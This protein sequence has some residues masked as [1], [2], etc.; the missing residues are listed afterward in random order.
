MKKMK[1]MKKTFYFVRHAEATHNRDSK[2]YHEF[3]SGKNLSD[4]YLDSPLTEK[5]IEQC[6][7]LK[8]QLQEKLPIPD[9]I[10]SSSLSRAIQTARISYPDREIFASDRCIERRSV[11][12]SD[13]RSEINKLKTIFENVNF[14]DIHIDHDDYH[15]FESDKE[16]ISFA[17]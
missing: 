17:I 6:K 15:L 3:Y 1:K 16:N 13:K 9:L 11:N 14:D 10:I 5:G 8:E 4:E 2:I 12:I 7:I